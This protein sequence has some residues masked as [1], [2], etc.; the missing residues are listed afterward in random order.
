MTKDFYE[1]KK[2]ETSTPGNTMAG[3][4]RTPCDAIKGQNLTTI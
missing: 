1:V 4:Y 2:S 3:T